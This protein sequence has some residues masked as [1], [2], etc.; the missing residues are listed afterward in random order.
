MASAVDPGRGMLA[1]QHIVEDRGRRIFMNVVRDQ[2][3]RDSIDCSVVQGPVATS[4]SS[5]V[6]ELPVGVAGVGGD[7][8]SG[9]AFDHGM[10][11]IDGAA[12][13]GLSIRPGTWSRFPITAVF[14][15]GAATPS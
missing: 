2:F 11:V 7:L 4:E 8:S 3:C 6:I 14:S 13:R 1:G 15:I 12:S 9:A 10:T 5:G